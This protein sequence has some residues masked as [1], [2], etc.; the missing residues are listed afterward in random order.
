MTPMSIEELDRQHR[1]NA[2]SRL[3]VA[4]VLLTATVILSLAAA[5]SSRIETTPPVSS[6][7]TVTGLQERQKDQ[8]NQ[9]DRLRELFTYCRLNWSD[10]RCSDPTGGAAAG[11]VA[12]TQRT[13]ADDS[14]NSD[15]SDTENTVIVQQPRPVATPRE[16][17]SGPDTNTQ[18]HTYAQTSRG[19]SD[20]H[21][22]RN[23]P[24]NP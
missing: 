20:R 10:P 5:G 21:S 2:A 15:G 23:H 13:P 22:E 14:D 24:K 11:P 1:R 17:K 9:L 4:S 19:S 18:S 6:D 3:A 12:V 8:Q 16:P 7:S